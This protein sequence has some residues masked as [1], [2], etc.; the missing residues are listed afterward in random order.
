MK[1]FREQGGWPAL[2]TVLVILA[3]S[4]TL[5]FGAALTS[6]RD[7]PI[8]SGDAIS[9]DVAAANKIYFG[10]MVALDTSGNAVPASADNTL[11]V[12]GR[13][14]SQQDNSSG[15]AG[16]L[17]V[18]IGTGVFRFINNGTTISLDD[19]GKTAYV[20]DDQ[21]V[22]LLDNSGARPAAGRIYD[23]D[24]TGVWVMFAS[25]GS[26]AA[27]G[28]I[29]LSDLAADSVNSSKI[30]DDSIALAD[31]GD[32]SVDT[33][34]IVNAT[35]SLEDLDSGIAPGFIVPIANTSISESDADATITIT[36]V[37]VL[38]TDIAGGMLTNSTNPV[39]I[40]NATTATD[41]ITFVL[42]GNG[43]AG[44]EAFYWIFRAAQ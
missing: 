3:F 21:S 41:T 2:I 28:G 34:N 18:E 7:T 8:R 42:N 5:A 1:N 30:V 43:G 33:S 32:A 15:I 16:A 4:T 39:V 12:I 25:Q 13:A 14:E 6:D 40:L 37:G 31:M 35:V 19:I 17:T 27:T 22:D 36:H 38:A 20:V 44:T 26:T 23:V 24:S 11:R 9:V 29:E 10:A